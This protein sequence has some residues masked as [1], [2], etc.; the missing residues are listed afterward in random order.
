MF[1]SASPKKVG[2]ARIT[3]RVCFGFFLVKKIDVCTPTFS[4]EE[5]YVCLHLHVQLQCCNVTASLQT[6]G[7]F[8]DF[9][10]SGE[11]QITREFMKYVCACV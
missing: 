5:G 11:S 3:G 10:F 1:E 6:N 4:I 2:S 9:F 7:I 8:T